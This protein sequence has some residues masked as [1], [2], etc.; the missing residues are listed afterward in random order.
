MWPRKSAR[1]L[2]ALSALSVA[3]GCTHAPPYVNPLNPEQV[4]A[5]RISAIRF[6]KG[7]SPLEA[8]RATFESVTSSLR[9]S[10]ADRLGPKFAPGKGDT[11]LVVIIERLVSDG[12]GIGLETRT[13]IRPVGS[14]IVLASYKV[15]LKYSGL[16]NA[17]DWP[18]AVT[19][20]DLMSMLLSKN[21]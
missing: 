19:T 8:D 4:D 20:A 10:L 11:D 7:L 1:W 5:L 21:Q 12:T 14:F 16:P 15:G 17:L 6:E 18:V 13:E 9:R 2:V 3:A